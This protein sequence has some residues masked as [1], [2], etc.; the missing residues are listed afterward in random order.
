M[1]CERCKE[2]PELLEVNGRRLCSECYKGFLTDVGAMLRKFTETR[3]SGVPC[4]RG[5]E[6]R[7]PMAMFCFKHKKPKTEMW[8]EKQER[9]GGLMRIGC[10]DCKAAARGAPPRDKKPAPSSWATRRSV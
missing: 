5:E 9:G 1:K 3:A 4:N 8:I 10:V 7:A 6:A 2:R